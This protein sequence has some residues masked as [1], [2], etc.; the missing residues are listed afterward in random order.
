VSDPAC[1]KRDKPTPALSS[2]EGGRNILLR[3]PW[4][5][6]IVVLLASIAATLNQFKVPPVMPLLMEDFSQSA[7]RAGL[8]MSV[9]AITGLFLAIPS[10]FILQR[11]GYRITGLMALSFVAA[12][13]GIG[14]FSNGIGTLL[15][16][17]LTE[18]AGLSLIAVTA[19]DIVALRFAPENRGKAM[20]VWSIW[21]PLGSTTMFI[22][23][24]LLTIRFGW[25][26]V[27]HFGWGYTIVIGLLFYLLVRTRTGLSW[28]QDHS[29][30]CKNLTIRRMG[31][32]MRNRNLWLISLL[33]CCFN[34]I[35]VSFLTWGPTFLQRVHHASIIRASHTMSLTSIMSMAAAQISGFLLD[36]TGAR[37]VIC[38]MPLLVM[39]FLF[40]A[41]V[42]VTEGMFLVLAA[43]IGFVS[44][45]L[46]TGVFSSAADVVGDERLAGM[47]MAV[48]QIG[49]N[50]GMLLGPLVF[51]LLIEYW[52]WQ[53]AF[54][55]LAP[56]GVIGTI[57][58]LIANFS[59]QPPIVSCDA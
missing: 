32:I 57:S 1:I 33:F 46:P 14:A 25:R 51:G 30:A 53:A 38:A 34:V 16:S 49:Q 50:T 12:G 44:G 45:F 2:L 5:I 11:L 41:N 26:G 4:L 52:G 9:F 13:A 23:A 39:A 15:F 55:A 48:I 43:A 7:G 10:G 3:S 36:R 59:R 31:R 6:L 47:A 21:V 54:W 56:I 29:E 18:G 42:I 37:K 58:A 17:R 8:L 27:W 35:V 28:D 24:P 20:A 40:P 22:L 19:P